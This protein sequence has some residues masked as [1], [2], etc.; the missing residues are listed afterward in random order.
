MQYTFGVELHG[1]IL[2]LEFYSVLSEQ[3]INVEILLWLKKTVNVRLPVKMEP[4]YDKR[5]VDLNSYIENKFSI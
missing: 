3:F 5:V 2:Y 4:A 1:E